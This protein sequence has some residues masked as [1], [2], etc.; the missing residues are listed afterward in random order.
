MTV[1]EFGHKNM[2]VHMLIIVL[3]AVVVFSVFGSIVVYNRLISLRHDVK[4]LGEQIQQEQVRNAELKNALY[5]QVQRFDPE[6]FLS[7]RGYV[8][9]T[10][11]EYRQGVTVSKAR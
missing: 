9:D 7:D 2:R 11:P 1:I 4:L 10:H 8:P 6:S 3:G 5:E